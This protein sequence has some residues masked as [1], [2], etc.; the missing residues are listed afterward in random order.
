MLQAEIVRPRE[1]S[2]GDLAAWDAFRTAT[3]ALRSPLLSAEFAL[4]VAE[5]RE[6][7]AVAVFRR[8]GRVVGFLA[9]HRRP[10]G[11][12]RPIGS[13]WSDYHAL[14]AA[15]D[16]V[17]DGPEALRLARIA[18]FRFGALVDPSGAFA[19]AE[20]VG[21]DAYRIALAGPGEDYWE[22]LRAQSPKRFK[23]MRRLEHKLARVAGP[24]SLVA[25]DLDPAAFER[26]LSWKS[27]QLRRTGLHDVLHPPWS[28]ALMQSL[29]E[30]RDGR[31]QG[32]LLTLR[33][34][35]QPVA[36][37]FGVR[38]GE[39]YHPWIAA[40]DPAFAAYSPGL[41]FLSEA[42]R[43]MP[44]LGL[45]S[46]DLSAGSDHYKRP[47]ASE[48]QPV[49]EGVLRV[50]GGAIERSLTRVSGALGEGPARILSRVRRRIDHIAAA[51]LS[52]SGRVQGLAAAV[53]ASSRRLEAGT[54]EGES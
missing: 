22:R 32:L 27:Q 12:A 31:L 26:L 10:A 53:A 20:T 13:S 11:L 42:I 46:Y 51:E 6:D 30:T 33:V 1:L 43:A 25:P 24:V 9:H 52:L 34:G 5:A 48:T 39:A 19:A 47:F 17:L 16:A 54:G 29:F 18:A 28:R 3:P 15:P 45:L 23:N 50:Q 40:Y 35:E 49:A 44:R 14:V 8:A 41:T 2:A 4:A 36:A 21:H 37:H 38:E 7:A